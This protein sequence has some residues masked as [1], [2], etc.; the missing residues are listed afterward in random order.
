MHENKEINRARERVIES[1]AK[2]MSLYGVTPSVGRLYGSLYFSQAPMTLDDMKNELG[3]SK[4]SMSTAVRQLQDLKMVE[5]I[6]QKGVRKDLY[7]ANE[8]WH[9]T[10]ID[11]FSLKWRSVTQKNMEVIN[12]SYNDLN[13]LLKS[14][15]VH[16]NIKLIAMKDIEK[17]KSALSYYQWLDR[18]IDLLESEAIF[19]LVPHSQSD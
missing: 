15:D 10:F 6:W 17:L 14:E 12:Q 16:P 11:F 3:M 2:N 4:T 8:D 18:F 5:K 1:I 19:E 13:Q 9:Q 7:E